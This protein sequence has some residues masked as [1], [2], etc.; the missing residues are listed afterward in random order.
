MVDF[1]LVGLSEVFNHIASRLIISMIED[2]VLG[3]HVPLDLMDFVRTMWSILSHNN[4]TFK[5]SVDVRLIMTDES[6]F[7]QGFAVFD[8]EEFRDVV[9]DE[10]EAAL[11][12]PGGGEEARPGGYL[13]LEC[14]GLCW[15]KK[16][17]VS[18]DLTQV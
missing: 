10:V 3:V 9:D 14:F 18:T 7:D 5:L 12:D 6:I 17:W 8:R 4:R 11:E 2:V 15:H 1:D 16:S 13:S